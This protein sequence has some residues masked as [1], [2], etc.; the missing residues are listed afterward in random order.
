[1]IFA[2]VMREMA[3]SYGRSS[4]GYLWAILEP[5]GGIIVLTVALSI[6]LN[7]PPIGDSFALFYAT[8][9]MPFSLYGKVQSSI[10]GAV[11]A[12]KQLLFYPEVSY[13]DAILAR[14]ILNFLTQALV[15]IIVIGGIVLLFGIR[16]NIDPGMGALS[17]ALAAAVGLGVGTINIALADLFPSWTQL[18]S[19][20]NRPLFLASGVFFMFDSMPLWAQDILWYNPLIHIVG[21]MRAAVFSTYDSTYISVAYVAAFAGLTFLAGLLMLRRYAKDIINI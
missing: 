19:I 7:A 3:T 11:R 6:V 14:F 9:F 18:W 8:G 10:M 17:L 5:I 2:L 12:N 15:A 4:I 20:I 1:V 21:L 16:L 13:M